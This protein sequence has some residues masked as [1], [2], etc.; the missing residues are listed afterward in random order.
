[1]LSASRF[2]WRAERPGDVFRPISMTG[3]PSLAN[4]DAIIIYLFVLSNIK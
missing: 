1:M 2:S 3:E 4:D